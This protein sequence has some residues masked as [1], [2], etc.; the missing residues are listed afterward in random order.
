MM[1]WCE[2]TQ[3]KVILG[4]TLTTQ[5]DGKNS[6]NALGNVHNEGRHELTAS[7]AVQRAGTLTRD[8]LYRLLKLNGYSDITPRR[9]CRFE[10]DNRQP[11]DMKKTA[12]NLDLLVRSGVPVP[13]AWALA[14]SGIPAA[15]DDEPLLQLP[16]NLPPFIGAS[17]NGYNCRC[18]VRALTPAQLARHPIGLESTDDYRVTVDQPQGVNGKMRP[19]T[20][21]KYPKTGQVFTP[22]AG[23]H[24]NPGKGYL[25]HLSEQLLNRAA[26]ADTRLAAQAVEETL[27]QPAL[28]NAL[29]RDTGN[30][31]S[32][33]MAQR[34]ARGDFRPVGALRPAVVDALAGKGVVPDLAVITLTDANLLHAT[35]DSKQG[36][37]PAIFWSALVSSLYRPCTILYRRRRCCCTSST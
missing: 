20:G 31:V 9:M 27:G 21:L 28:L 14:E 15:R 2:S 26:R 13:V 35:R 6:T 34:Q 24:L 23:F 32:Q 11:R 33:V 18:R 22:D 1:Q 12:E 5:A 37:L 16:G 3:S 4:G 19:V 17:P 7:D 30:W 10:F 8:L 36:A 25:C 29:N